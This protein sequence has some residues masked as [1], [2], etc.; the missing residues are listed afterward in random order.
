MKHKW[1][2]ETT[3]WA[4]QYDHKVGW[5]CE[6]TIWAFNSGKYDHSMS[7]TNNSQLPRA[8]MI[9]ALTRPEDVK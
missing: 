5:D 4:M 1:R 3:A 2:K 6:G 7:T 8:L 9:A